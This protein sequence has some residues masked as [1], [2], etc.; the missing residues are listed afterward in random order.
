[1]AKKVNKNYDVT[2][3]SIKDIMDIDLD[4]FNKLSERELKQI[5]SRLVSAANKRIRA[6]EKKDISSPAVRSLGVNNRFSVKLTGI[7][8]T[9]RVNTIKHEF[10]RARRFLIAKTSTMKGYKQYQKDVKEEVESAIGRKVTSGEI[11]HAFDLL[12]KMQERGLVDG[13][14]GSAGSLQARE[15]IFDILNDNPNLDDDD[16]MDMIENEYENYYEENE[17]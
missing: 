15:M 16:L 14:R 10:A 6:F 17:E 9:Q 7:D 2:G 4:K 5:T 8:K 12:H 3:L 13:K 1:M 11:G